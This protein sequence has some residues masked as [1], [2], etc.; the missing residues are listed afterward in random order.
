MEK[1]IVAFAHIEDLVSMLPP[2]R[3]VQKMGKDNKEKTNS[4]NHFD[5]T[6]MDVGHFLLLSLHLGFSRSKEE[7]NGLKA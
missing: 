3:E 6:R 2:V 7:R 4:P 5:T 1:K